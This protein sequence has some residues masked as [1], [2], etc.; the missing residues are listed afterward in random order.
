MP[1]ILTLIK[2][3][4][5]PSHLA[6]GAHAG[7]SLG[8]ARRA[9]LAREEAW[10]SALRLQHKDRG[11]FELIEDTI[12]PDFDFRYLLIRD[13][14]GRT[15]AVQPFFLLDQD[16]LGGF[17]SSKLKLVRAIRRFWPRFLKLRTL[18]IGCAAGEGHLSSSAAAAQRGDAEILSSHITRLAR[19][20][21]ASL[22]VLKEFPARYRSAL[23]SL[24]PRGFAR[25]PSMPMTRLGLAAYTS[26][27]DYMLKAIKA[28][29]RNELRRKLKAAQGAGPIELETLSDASAIVDEIYPL[30]LQVFERSGLQ[31][32]KLTKA[33]FR[34]IGSKMP[35][36]TLF[37]IWRQN[38]K[39]IAF[40]LCLVDGDTLYG[41]YIGLDY[42]VAL[43]LHL[44]F[45]VMRDIISW[46]IANGYRSIVSS[47][48]N[49]APKLLLRHVLEPLDLYVR[50]TS[51]LLNPILRLILPILE[52]TRG[53]AALR[54]FPNYCELWGRRE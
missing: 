16:L 35:D 21:R 33:F 48:L 46:A 26:F 8:I 50:H 9:D 11:Y 28:K 45:Y 52:P 47:G 15:R 25:I 1:A 10:Q 54:L 29:R 20:E 39:V 38:G 12:C 27:D 32:E 6:A 43:D 14:A 22:V 41:E 3:V 24:L 17:D 31:F 51:P 30:Y 37:F 5:L 42:Q 34:E 36:K 49:Y 2:R 13:E 7:G 23:S 18:M 40:S 19:N 53:D 44:Y 4:A